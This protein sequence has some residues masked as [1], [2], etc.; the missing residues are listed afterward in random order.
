MRLYFWKKKKNC[1]E[2]KVLYLKKKLHT[3]VALTPHNHNPQLPA[4][5]NLLSVFMVLPIPEI[6]GIIQQVAF[7]V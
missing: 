3:H 2:K 7:C 4:T 6:N 1:K 5:A